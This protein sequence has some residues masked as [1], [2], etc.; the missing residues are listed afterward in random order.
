MAERKLPRWMR[1][2]NIGYQI[3]MS[4]LA[5]VNFGLSMWEQDGDKVPK[6]HLKICS[7]LA[8]MLPVVWS[9]ILDSAKEYQHDLTPSPSIQPD[10]PSAR[11]SQASVDVVDR[12]PPPSPPPLSTSL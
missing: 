10:S 4:L 5:A 8:A 6:V 2:M 3:L 12:T 1:K 7:I 9:K 11:T